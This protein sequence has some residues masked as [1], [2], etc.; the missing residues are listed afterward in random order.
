MPDIIY[1]RKFNI[2]IE[3]EMIYMSTKKPTQNVVIPAYI[4]GNLKTDIHNLYDEIVDT[5]KSSSI[6]G[7]DYLTLRKLASEIN[8]SNTTL[9]C[10]I[11]TL[12]KHNFL[13]DYGLI[14]RNSSGI[15]V[16]H[17]E[18]VIF[19]KAYNSIKKYYSITY[20]DFLS[21]WKAISNTGK[22]SPHKKSKFEKEITKEVRDTISSEMKNIMVILTEETSNST[23]EAIS[24]LSE[25]IS[26]LERS[27]ESDRVKRKEDEEE[28]IKKLSR[29][30]IE[31][32]RTQD[33]ELERLKKINDK[34]AEEIDSINNQIKKQTSILIGCIHILTD[35]IDKMNE[36]INRKGGPFSG[37]LKL[38]LKGEIQ[39]IEKTI[40]KMDEALTYTENYM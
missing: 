4:T 13:S 2:N 40:K 24:E 14:S 32:L 33:D 11:D 12:E 17:P 23:A 37:F 3:K 8:I 1:K 38:C 22:M 25:K 29:S 16:Y 9:K 26:T 30:I 7:I 31:A 35:S 5:V 18:A 19:F 15:P 27:I 28:L 21:E 36:D 20:R 34:Q 10:Q 6:E 39:N